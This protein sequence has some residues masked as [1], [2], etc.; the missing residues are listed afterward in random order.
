MD[1]RKVTY[2]N[3]CD[4]CGR[5]ASCNRGSCWGCMCRNVCNFRIQQTLPKV[6]VGSCKSCEFDSEI[7]TIRTSQK[8]KKK[9]TYYISKP[10]KKKKRR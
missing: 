8:V 9:P 3:V 1:D 7:L 5:V 2:L 10:K 4:L 6:R